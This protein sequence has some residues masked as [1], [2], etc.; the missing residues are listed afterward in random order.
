[1]RDDVIYTGH[2][3]GDQPT[4]RRTINNIFNLMLVLLFLTS[5]EIP[6]LQ[7][8][9][10][11]DSELNN[12]LVDNSFFDENPCQA[13]CWYDLEL[14][15]STEPEVLTNLRKLSFI[16]PAEVETHLSS[17]WMPNEQKNITAKLI[18]AYCTDP[19]T[20][21]CAALIVADGSLKTITLFPNRFI[22]IRNVVDHLGIPD[23]V[24][25]IHTFT[26]RC[27]IRL[28][29][30]QK[31]ILIEVTDQLSEKFCKEISN[32][33]GINANLKINSIE[34]VIPD[35]IQLTSIP[36]TGRDFKWPGF[37]NP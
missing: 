19:N 30:I 16:N 14:G 6:L 23:Y 10:P 3:I 7:N 32:G 25:V 11:E 26:S 20:Q 35:D 5:C 21:L 2:K 9:L 18:S 36:E 1:M 22:S 27:R 13:P 4:T 15:K 28:V 37:S 8:N 33:N 24:Q 34:Y 12:R 17:Y 31:Q 29:W